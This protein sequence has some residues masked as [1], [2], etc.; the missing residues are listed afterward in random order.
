M[1]IGYRV[2]VGVSI[3]VTALTIGL[4]Y[5]AVSAPRQE[6][7]KKHPIDVAM[8]ACIKK[9]SSTAGMVECI[10]AARKSWDREMNGSYQK[11]IG[12]L[13]AKGKNSLKTA[14]VQW[15]RYRDAELK[16]IESV[17]SRTQGTIYLPMMADDAM[18]LTR[19]RARELNGYLDVLEVDP[20]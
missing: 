6:T 13:D 19:Q 7:E 15:I 5:P 9:D 1:Q 2:F 16:T 12:K 8:Q 10:G 4:L 20:R 11:L 14:Q 17:Y 18:Q 3:S